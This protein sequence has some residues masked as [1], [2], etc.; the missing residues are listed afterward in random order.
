M[1]ISYMNTLMEATYV[2]MSLF[3]YFKP[4]QHTNSEKL[5]GNQS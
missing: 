5:Y 3:T 4:N 2:K 1:E